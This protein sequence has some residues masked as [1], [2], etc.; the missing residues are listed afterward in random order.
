MYHSYPKGSTFPDVSC[1]IGFLLMPSSPKPGEPNK[2]TP[3]NTVVTNWVDFFKQADGSA[4]TN[5]LFIA[6]WETCYGIKRVS[7]PK[8]GVIKEFADQCKLVMKEEKI[9]PKM[10]QILVQDK[11]NRELKG[12]LKDVDYWNLPAVVQVAIASWHVKSQP[13]LTRWMKTSTWHNMT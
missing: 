5:D 2:Q 6:D 11:L 4:A 1:G 13:K 3:N 12:S 10:A 7:H 9:K 8:N